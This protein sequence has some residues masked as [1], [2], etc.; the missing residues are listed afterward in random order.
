MPAAAYLF[1]RLSGLR[2]PIPALLAVATTAFLFDT[3]FT[4]LPVQL[5]SRKWYM[6]VPYPGITYHVE[7]GW[8]SD[9][10]HFI[11]ILVSNPS[12][13]P[14]TWETT[15]LRLKSLKGLG[16]DSDDVIDY[17]LRVTHPLGASEQGAVERIPVPK[18]ARKELHDFG[19]PD[20]LSSSFGTKPQ[21]SRRAPKARGPRK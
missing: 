19:G 6:K 10:G 12:D 4:M 3:N 21:G 15:R 17:H 13:A 5:D 20:S 14:E 1:G 11:P 7:I 2:Y 16:A 18:P 9:H 8:L